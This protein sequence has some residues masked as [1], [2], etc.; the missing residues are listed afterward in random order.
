[1]YIYIIFVFYILSAHYISA[2]KHGK[3]KRNITQQYFGIVD[4][5]FVHVCPIFTHLKLYKSRQPDTTSCGGGGDGRN[6]DVNACLTFFPWI[7]LLPC[8]LITFTMFLNFSIDDVYKC[9]SRETK[10]YANYL[11]PMIRNNTSVYLTIF[12]LLFVTRYL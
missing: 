8:S 5:D 10:K 11:I 1:M 3:V 12:V 4:L 6:C 7:G 9:Y 2:F